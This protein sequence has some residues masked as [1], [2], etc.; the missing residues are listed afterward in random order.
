MNVQELY[1]EIK[2]ICK[3]VFKEESVAKLKVAKVISVSAP[4]ATVL[5]SGY[6]T[7]ITIPNKTNL[8][9]V[10]NDQVVCVIIGDDMSNMFIGWKI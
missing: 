7:N 2:K 3:Q 5:L 1:F 9:L 4:N 10:A 8:T 6:T